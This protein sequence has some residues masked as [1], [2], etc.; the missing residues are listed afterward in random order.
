MDTY[1][2]LRRPL[3]TEKVTRLGEQNK[4]AFQVD[5]RANRLEVKQAVEKAFNVKVQSVNILRVKGK[6]KRLGHRQFTTPGWKK[7]LVTLREGHKIQFI[8][9]V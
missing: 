1:Q 9:G 8:E 3:I 5:P 6:I 4:Y 7:A 2:V